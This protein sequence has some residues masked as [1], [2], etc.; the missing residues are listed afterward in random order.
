MIQCRHY[1][2]CVHLHVVNYPLNGVPTAGAAPRCSVIVVRCQA[3]GS[4]PHAT[5]NTRA[6]VSLSPSAPQLPSM[7][8]LPSAPQLP[9]VPWLPSM[10][11]W[12]GY[13]LHPSCPLC[14]GCPLQ[15]SCP[16][17]PGCPLQPSC[18][19]YPDFFTVS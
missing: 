4:Q 18:P 6:I 15:P 16:L 1:K 8:W 13:P 7:A 11:L 12:S 9:S 3:Q 2:M 17:W 19:L 10:S 5:E 14:P